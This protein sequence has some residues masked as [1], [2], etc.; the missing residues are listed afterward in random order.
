MA[1]LSCTFVDAYGRTSSRVYGMEDQ[2]LLAD[3]IAAATAFLTA[4]QA[5]TDLGLIK[6]DLII[7][8]SGEEWAVTAG[9]NVD[10]GATASGWL[11][12]GLGKKASL[13]YPA[14]KA[15][16]IDPDGS[17]PI[18]GAVATFLAEFTTGEDFN[19]S[20]GEQIE[21][22]IKAALDK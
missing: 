2:L 14:P 8:M 22:W 9:A 10:T 5:V 3:Y 1:K 15:A 17:I 20:D 12:A 21:S 16:Q 4:Y 18:V 11:D 7:P 13:K 19:L 6:A